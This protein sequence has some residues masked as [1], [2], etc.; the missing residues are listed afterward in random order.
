M[1]RPLRFGLHSVGTD[2]A[3]DA[4]NAEALGFDVLTVADHL[5]DGLVD[6]FAGL[7]AAASATSTIR[8]GTLVLNNDLRNP[9]IVARQAL[10]LDAM[11]GGR[12]EL[13]LGAGHGWPEY[14]QAG[15]PFDPPAV[16]VARLRET[17]EALDGLLRGDTVS[18]D[19]EHVHVREH[20]SF[21][22]AVQTPRMPLLVGGHAP[23]V[24]RVGAERCDIVGLSG[25]GK[26]MADGLRHEAT[27][28]KADVVDER[29]ALIRDVRADVEINVLVQGVV[30][31]DDPS[32]EAAK[33]VETAPYLTV[34]DVLAAPYVWI[35]T[36]ESICD[37]I[38]SYR[39]RWGMTYFT[40]FGRSMEAAAPI[41][42]RLASEG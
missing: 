25:T 36:V 4:V 13:G 22:P 38:S 31:T 1:T 8:L 24:L 18:V 10:A 16:R 28:F 19:G 5:V 11:S 15:I 3:T 7:T 40:V 34:D 9:V 32:A 29:V 35:G 6:P 14:E 33:I 20:R 23:S 41:V 2:P 12:L 17:I 30:I 42:A 21:P 27:G 37:D 39:D 26:T